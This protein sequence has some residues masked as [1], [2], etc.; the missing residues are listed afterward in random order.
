MPISLSKVLLCNTYRPTWLFFTLHNHVVIIILLSTSFCWNF[1]F[2]FVFVPLQ[3]LENSRTMHNNGVV[4]SAANRTPIMF[5]QR[6]TDQF[7]RAACTMTQHTVAGGRPIWPMTVF[8][9]RSVLKTIYPGVHTP[10]LKPI[11]GGRSILEVQ[12]QSIEWI[13]PTEL[14]EGWVCSYFYS[15]KTRANMTAI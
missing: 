10:I 8:V 1:A 6:W 9:K 3:K 7:I 14:K 12:Q 15:I 13:W 4:Y 5:K 11:H 2:S